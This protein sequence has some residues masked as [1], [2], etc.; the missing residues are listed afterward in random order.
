MLTAADNF[1]AGH[2]KCEFV[3]PSVILSVNGIQGIFAIV[4]TN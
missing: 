4:I 2:D 3:V 1:S